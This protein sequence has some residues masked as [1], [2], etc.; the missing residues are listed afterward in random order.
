VP[1]PGTAALSGRPV[2]AFAGIA[3][4]R[5]FFDTLA[6]AGAIVVGR[7]TFADHYP[8]DEADITALLAEAE[9][10]AA[11]PVTT[12]KDIVR[13]PA[14]FRDQIAVAGVGLAWEDEEALDALLTPL[15]PPADASLS[16]VPPDTAPCAA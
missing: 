15:F 13:V 8:Y 9:S 3:N 16:T 2:L 10:L 4:P 1:G 7:Q 6:E 5:K 11:L 14:R 12:R